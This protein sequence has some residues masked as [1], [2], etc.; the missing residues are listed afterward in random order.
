MNGFNIREQVQ[1]VNFLSSK[2]VKEVEKLLKQEMLILDRFAAE[3]LEKE[4]LEYDEIESIFNEFGK[5]QEG[6]RK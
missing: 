2:C 6:K 3:L 5:E 1:F 4:E